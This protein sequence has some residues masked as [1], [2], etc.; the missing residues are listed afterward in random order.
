MKVLWAASA[1]R[2]ILFEEDIVLP[3]D[4]ILYLARF[5][6]FDD[7][8]NFIR[9]FWPANN[10]CD[11]VRNKLWQMS[12]HEIS[13]PFLNGKRVKIEYNFDASRMPEH[14]ILFNVETLLPIF[15]GVVP[16]RADKFLS[17]SRLQNFIRMHVHLNMCFGRQYAACLCHEFKH[18]TH[19]GVRIVKPSEVA[20]KYGHFHHYCS[21]HV[22]NWLDFCLIPLVQ[23]KEKSS[24]VEDDMTES[25]VLFMSNTVHLDQRWDQC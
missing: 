24:S 5:L 15:G 14:R 1:Q 3:L 22:R 11:V 19:T 4:I 16:P 9:C 23:L 10:E 25:F 17:A 7:Y 6:Q 2:W 13:I 20:C 8:R 12:T 18:N 21:L